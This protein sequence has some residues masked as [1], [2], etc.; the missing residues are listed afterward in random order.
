MPSRNIP[1]YCFTK[2]ASLHQSFIH[3]SGD[4][5]GILYGSRGNASMGVARGDQVQGIAAISSTTP[6]QQCN[7]FLYI[8][9]LKHTVHGNTL[10]VY[11][12]SNTTVSTQKSSCV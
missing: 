9:W 6:H 5:G 7:M 1:T 11:I 4:I 3:R 2:Y 8:P 12:Q 10:A